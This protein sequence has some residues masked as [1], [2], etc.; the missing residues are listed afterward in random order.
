MDRFIS[1][2]KVRE[3][4]DKVTNVVMNY[5]EVEGKVREATSD[6]AWGPTGQQMQ[7]LAL[8]TFTYE[9]FPEVMSM[10]WRRML[11]D[12]R[13]HWRR[14][15]KCLLLLSYLV[16]NGSERVVTSAREHIYDLRSLENYTHVDDLGKDQGINVRHK[17]RELI[18]FIQD[19]DKLRDERKK[20]KKNK[21]K[22][23]GMSSEATVM[24]TRSGSGGWG[25]YSDRGAGN[26]EEPKD[27]SRSI[28]EEEYDRADDSDG[29]YS[30][31]RSTQP[32]PSKENVYRDTREEDTPPSPPR[33]PSPVSAPVGSRPRD[34]RALN[35]QL[36]TPQKTKSSTPAKKIDLGAA[37]SYGKSGAPASSAPAAANTNKSQELLDD[38]FKT[39]AAPS[40]DDFDP[41]ADDPKPAKEPDFGD[42]TA[43]FTAPESAPPVTSLAPPATS[44]AGGDGFADFSSAF[45]GGDAGSNGF[46]VLGNSQASN[47]DLLSSLSP[48]LV[49]PLS[50][51][52]LDGPGFDGPGFD[53]GADAL[54]G[55]TLM[56]TPAG[57]KEMASKTSVQESLLRDLKTM[58]ATLLS[59]KKL[60]SESEVKTIQKY[61]ENIIHNLP[62][63]ITIQKLCRVDDYTFNLEAIDVL[64]Q[65]QSSVIKFVLPQWPIFKD[66]VE[67]IFV[68]EE[69]F[70]V[71]RE[72]LTVL[73]GFLQHECNI[74]SIEALSF[75]LLKFVKSDCIL[76]SVVDC[77][78]V[79]LQ[80]NYRLYQLQSDWQNYVQLIVTLPE[81]V[82]NKLE[83]RTPKEFSHENYSYILIFQIIRSIDYMAESTFHH[84]VQYDM[85]YLAHLVSK[86]VVHYSMAGNSEAMNKFIDVIVFWVGKENTEK[87]K[88][89]KKKLFH[90]LVHHMTR[91]ALDTFSVI[92]MK[93][94]VINYK[95][96]EQSILEVLG[97]NIDTNKDLKQVLCYKIPFNTVPKDYKNTLFCENLVYYISTSS[98]APELLTDFIL[99]L[100]LVWS[101][102][103]SLNTTNY[104]QHMFISQI[105]VLAVKY[106]LL[107]AA[108]MKE[109]WDSQALKNVLFMGISKHLDSLSAEF[110]TIGMATVEIILN[111][112]KAVEDKDGATL[113]F[114]Y[115]A[116]CEKFQ[117]IHKT[118]FKLDTK[119][120]LDPNVKPPPKYKEKTININ[121]VLDSIAYK[122]VEEDEKP[123]QNTLITSA[124]K[125]P[126][127]TKEIIKTIIAE[128]LSALTKR[129]DPDP[130]LDSDDELQPYDMSNDLPASAKK[131]PAFLRDLI[132]KLTDAADIEDYEACLAVA[133]DL[134]HAQ[135]KN[136]DPKLAID[137]LNLFI[138]LESKYNIED[139]DNIRFA[140]CIAIVVAQP[141]VSAEHLCKEFHSD[142]GRYSIATKILMLDV[143][144]ESANRISDVRDGPNK[145]PP[146]KDI[147]VKQTASDDNLPAE[148]I[149]R[150]RLLN[151]VKYTHSK[152][153]HPF[154][155]AKRNQFAAVS[156]SF[157][158][159]LVSGFGRKQL[160]LSYHNLKQDIDNILLIKY[161]SVVGNIILA[162]KNCPNCPKYCGELMEI[163]LYLR[164]NSEPK[165][166][167]CVMS[168]IASII[169]AVPKSMIIAEF[170]EYMVDFREW[171][172]DC[173]NQ[174][175]LAMVGGPKAEAAVIAGQTLYLLEK[176]IM[177][178]ELP[179]VS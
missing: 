80:E 90:K 24:G 4:A 1:M 173:V 69:N 45:T 121:E 96:Q 40:E 105:L 58:T 142:I 119:C 16:R 122:L 77:S 15:Y 48:S 49:A 165:I 170:L 29:D 160:S 113:N 109:K 55:L 38:L 106:R 171:L 163:L 61:F 133:E 157:F 136:D 59:I 116:I 144:S 134:V 104:S 111:N 27:R 7:E 147:V 88:F 6:E 20:A 108:N 175:D 140:I 155:K 42:F 57:G 130:D 9:H 37:A 143:L 73:C 31:P 36:K 120:L 87:T 72:T 47:L 128:K 85:S 162:S 169:L 146:K 117:E 102:V 86:F 83:R 107:M 101:D 44:L 112:L 125:T 56:P 67:K 172:N 92:L 145:P 22:Y 60:K 33:A 63:P 97:D 139:F 14:T 78:S 149:I 151:K 2:W 64:S 41:R 91:Q 164:Y 75:I 178:E 95:N 46:D 50:A 8:A 18:D 74:N 25:E 179:N 28:D 79:E 84:D 103:K 115:T 10:L 65:M 135:L 161:L 66:T 158:Y 3:L 62:G 70:E 167:V 152:R 52:S 82:A 12:N 34:N 53:S 110:R 129:L 23:I 17:V 127:Q 168:L 26:W 76:S 99:R 114:D 123:V 13:A 131:R 159:P 89:I 81:R 132:E 43:A 94:C 141:K 177:E 39:C 153:L 166:Q 176:A 93:R 11:H 174:M 30:T 19:D 54:A 118:L 126:T 98:T 148:E 5:T 100:G 21:D 124:V 138:H 154:A 137:L 32:Q 51:P 156:D 68:I 71:V 150:R 35:I